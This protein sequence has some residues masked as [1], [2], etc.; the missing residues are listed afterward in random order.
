MVKKDDERRFYFEVSTNDNELRIE[1]N[2]L[3]FCNKLGD[4]FVEFCNK[5]N[6][7]IYVKVPKYIK[8]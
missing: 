6:G 5:Y 8:F 1:C 7:A 3:D 2:D 4:I